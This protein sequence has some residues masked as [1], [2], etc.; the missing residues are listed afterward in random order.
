VL[1]HKTLGGGQ[2]DH[3]LG[4]GGEEPA[5][6]TSSFRLAD[7]VDWH[8]RAIEHGLQDRLLKG[9]VLHRRIQ[10]AN[11]SRQNRD[12]RIECAQVLGAALR[13]RRSG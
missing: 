7:F 13:R 10:E 6:A 4:P 3:L 9:V 12:A 8:I 5:L 2:S 1:E 11:S